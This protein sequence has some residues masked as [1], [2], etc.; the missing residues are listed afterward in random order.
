MHCVTCGNEIGFWTKLT[1]TKQEVC[2]A[3]HEQGTK[4]LQILVQSVGATPKLNVQHAERWAGQFEETVQK[5]RLPDIEVG[6]L[7]VSFLNN[8]FKV[9]EAQDVS[10][11]PSFSFLRTSRENMT[12]GSAPLRN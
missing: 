3:C 5:Y 4:Q 8:M 11:T 6:N 9:I 7:L 2:R 12:C 1:H 10:P